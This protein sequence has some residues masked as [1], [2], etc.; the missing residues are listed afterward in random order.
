MMYGGNITRRY[1]QIRNGREVTPTRSLCEFIIYCPDEPAHRHLAAAS[2]IL[3]DYGIGSSRPANTR[4]LGFPLFD[5]RPDG[6]RDSLAANILQCLM[7]EKVGA[8]GTTV[9]VCHTKGMK[10]GSLIHEKTVRETYGFALRRVVKKGT[11]NL[12]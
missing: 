10:N 9:R 4:V 6:P 5:K 2:Q 7:E 3:P 8:A 12:C 11:R 1:R